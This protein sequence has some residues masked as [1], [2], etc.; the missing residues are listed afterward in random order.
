MFRSFNSAR[1]LTTSAWVPE[2]LNWGGVTGYTL[3]GSPAPRI[4]SPVGPR[5]GFHTPPISLPASKTVGWSP[6]ACADDSHGSHSRVRTVEVALN[7]TGRSPLRRPTLTASPVR[8][9]APHAG[10]ILQLLLNHTIEAL[11]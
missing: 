11:K 9:G 8:S 1:A 2:S 10:E 6:L 3:R 7:V 4:P 5:W